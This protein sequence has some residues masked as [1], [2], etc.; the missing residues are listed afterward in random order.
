MR[1]TI[2]AH[3]ESAESA[4]PPVH[5]TIA[6]NE[7]DFILRYL[8]YRLFLLSCY[9]QPFFLL[10]KDIRPWRRHS[11]PHSPT[12][13]AVQL[14]HSRTKYRTTPFARSAGEHYWWQSG[15][16]SGCGSHARIR[17]WAT[18]FE[19][20][21]RVFS[22]IFDHPVASR[23]GNGCLFTFETHRFETRFV[24]NLNDAIFVTERPS[25]FPFFFNLNFDIP[26]QER[27][28]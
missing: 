20:V 11:A 18:H 13:P 27:S 4:L 8:N 21:C 24:P 22:R 5:V 12:S 7:I 15:H 25:A 17:F 28:T 9:P 16:R 3:P 19:G 2:E 1:A 6:N 10:K 23:I 26:V 14:Q